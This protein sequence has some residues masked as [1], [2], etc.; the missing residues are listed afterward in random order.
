[1]E[2]VPIFRIR[3]GED[4]GISISWLRNHVHDTQSMLR[5]ASDVSLF[6]GIGKMKE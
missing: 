2:G 5:H 6:D 1:M 3:D 4:T